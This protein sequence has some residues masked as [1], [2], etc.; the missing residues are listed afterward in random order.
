MNFVKKYHSIL[1]DLQAKSQTSI[2]VTD[3]KKSQSHIK[4]GILSTGES[5]ASSAFL[6]SAAGFTLPSGSRKKEGGVEFNCAINQPL[7]SGADNEAGAGSKDAVRGS[8]F[9]LAPMGDLSN[10]IFSRMQ[11]S[12]TRPTEK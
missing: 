9:Q 12:S 6:S 5:S 7:E 2:D 8:E 3:M 1:V 10:W 4:I 11:M